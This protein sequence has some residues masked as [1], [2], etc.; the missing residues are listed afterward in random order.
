[1]EHRKHAKWSVLYRPKARGLVP[2]QQGKPVTHED[3]APP[4]SNRTRLA[5][6]AYSLQGFT[7]LVGKVDLN[8]GTHADPV[9]GYVALSRFN[10]LE[11]FQ[12]GALSKQHL[13]WMPAGQ[14]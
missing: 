8:L 4:T 5:C 13:I 3:T 11:I 10:E 12:Q 9:T 2:G 6:T 7:L 14:S 1:M